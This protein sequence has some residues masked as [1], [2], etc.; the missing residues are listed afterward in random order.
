MTSHLITMVH[1]PQAFEQLSVGWLAAVELRVKQVPGSEQR[2]LRLVVDTRPEGTSDII[3]AGGERVFLTTHAEQ[4][5]SHITK[6]IGHGG[7]RF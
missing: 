7:F 2:R 3:G 4:A 6:L 5:A 1:R